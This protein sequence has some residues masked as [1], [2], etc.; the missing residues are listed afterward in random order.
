MTICRKCQTHNTIGS[1]YCSRCGQK[2][3]VDR[4]RWHRQSLVV[5]ALLVAAA[6]G[7]SYIAWRVAPHRFAF[8][9]AVSKSLSDGSE[10]NFDRRG[11]AI[12][13][14]ESITIRPL[15]PDKSTVVVPIG[16]LVIEDITGKALH[17]LVVPI[18]DSGWIALPMPW[19]IA[20]YRWRLWIDSRTDAAIEGGVFQDADGVG[21]WQTALSLPAPGP[22]LAPWNEAVPL[23]WHPLR[24]DASLKAVSPRGCGQL[25]YFIR[26]DMPYG[27]SGPG[28]FFQNDVVVGWT[29]E[30]AANGAF[31]WNGDSGDDLTAEIPIDDYYRQT[32]AESREEKWL[33]ALAEDKRDD[34]RQLDALLDA[35]RYPRKLADWQL[36]PNLDP[37]RM[38][39]LLQQLLEK[40][41]ADGYGTEVVNRFDRQVLLEINDPD[42]VVQVAELTG[43]I[44]G[45]EAA[46]NT[47]EW[48][49]DYLSLTSTESARFN[50]THREFYIRLLDEY[51]LRADWT[52]VAQRLAAARTQFPDD[53]QL[54]LFEVRLALANGNW[55][56]AEQILSVRT[57]PA[58][59]SGQVDRLQ[60]QIDRFKGSEG[61]VVVR[62]RPGSRNIR[63]TADLN[64]QVSQPFL[65]D[66]GAS[67]VTIPT[68]TAQRLGIPIGESA[69][70]QT[71]FT[72]G[73][74][75]EAREV[76]IDEIL[77]DGWRVQGVTAL[78]LD[79]PGQSDLG[80]L[81][82]NYL[83][84]FDM[85]LQTE[86][87]LLILTPK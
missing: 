83:S 17:R 35:Y 2:L 73:G 10:N 22:P 9:A 44:Y 76:T 32:F 11:D 36:P 34:L 63:V 70:M 80:L 23:Y 82:L 58:S 26:C 15:A 18:I 84:R 21:I 16:T 48:V 85:D 74:P 52:S 86:E 19:S 31:L 38:V 66:T 1:R 20:G 29:L 39:A 25:G 6:V 12:R 65:I 13:L 77:L 46:I 45:N 27:V 79:L 30:P 28:L 50:G 37:V 42:L 87:G 61:K 24:A 53:P 43:Q 5:L 72:A 68:A 40:L 81:G 78:V 69:P 55:K 14:E 3:I 67:V 7:L 71:V 75:V 33:L 47:I 49:K 41:A 51:A 62:F 56:D 57:Y 59:I 4:K 8:L 64:G 60:S 54:Y